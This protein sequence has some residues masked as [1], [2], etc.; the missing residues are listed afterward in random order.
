[1]FF[2]QIGYEVYWSP[3]IFD[4]YSWIKDFSSKNNNEF[5]ELFMLY[6]F[7]QS[8]NLKI[9]DRF[10]N[11]IISSKKIVKLL[12]SLGLKESDFMSHIVKADARKIEK[13][14]LSI[15]PNILN[16]FIKKIILKEILKIHLIMI[17][18]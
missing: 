3:K 4:L 7:S 10:F 2:Q 14:I 15:N 13:E 11:D 9:W 17:M 12:H 6:L 8:P 16:D 18:K 5:N 1:M